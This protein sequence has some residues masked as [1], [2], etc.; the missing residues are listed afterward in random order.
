M[1]FSLEHAGLVAHFEAHPADRALRPFF[2]LGLGLCSLVVFGYVWME[3]G[4]PES[5]LSALALHVLGAPMVAL[6][7]QSY[8]R[9]VLTVTNGQLLVERT[10][11]R[12]KRVS[13]ELAG[14]EVVAREE[15]VGQ[16]GQVLELGL[17]DV[18]GVEVV[19]DARPWAPGE[20]RELAELLRTA[21][22]M[23]SPRDQAEVP[24]ALRSL[25]SAEQR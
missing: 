24:A 18:N 9:Q 4:T 3:G 1:G 12:T 22:A 16:E 23:E 17:K 25:L 5:V 7:V 20:F 6:L 2:T 15:H 8:R 19:L 10:F 14:L 11:V 21:A 13:L